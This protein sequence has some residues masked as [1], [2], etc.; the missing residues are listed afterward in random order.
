[1]PGDETIG[2]DAAEQAS[3]IRPNQDAYDKLVA[4][5]RELEAM[6][7]TAAWAKLWD[8]V[9]EEIKFHDNAIYDPDCTS[10]Q[11]MQHRETVLA[12]KRLQEMVQAPVAQLDEME[13]AAE[14]D[15][16]LYPFPGQVMAAFDEESG[17]LTVR[18]CR[19][20]REAGA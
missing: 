19:N 7:Q 6:T 13:A 1:M 8:F 3:A 14:K 20:K 18:T 16:P 9:K 17:R 11:V 15:E 10:K 12:Y 2:A 4:R 5:L